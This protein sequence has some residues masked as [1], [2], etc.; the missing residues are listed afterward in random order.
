M[1]LTLLQSGDNRELDSLIEFSHQFSEPT[2][3][4]NIEFFI[5]EKKHNHLV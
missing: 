3:I 2:L 5:G 4:N 1:N